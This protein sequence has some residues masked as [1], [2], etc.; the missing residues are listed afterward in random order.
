MA[1]ALP[2]NSTP[3]KWDSNDGHSGLCHQISCNMTDVEIQIQETITTVLSSYLE[4]L[5]IARECLHHSK[6]FELELCQF[7]ASDF[8]KWKHRG[9]GKKEAWKMTAVCV[10]CIIEELYSEQVVARD[11]YDQQDPDFATTKYLWAT[12]KAHTVMEIYLHH[13]FC[14]HPLIS[15][16]LARHLADNYV[17]PD[18]S[19]SSKNKVIEAQLK[20]LESRQKT[21]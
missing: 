15:A 19:Q 12:W 21:L 4:A 17:K 1:E 10:R 13:Q 2:A 7:I 3:E 11:M 18:D 9:Q 16:V 6:R 5:H 14:K 8:Q 20:T